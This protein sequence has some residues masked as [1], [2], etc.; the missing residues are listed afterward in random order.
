MD[1]IFHG[2][3]CCGIK[4]IKDLR[5]SPDEVV[6]GLSKINVNDAD[7]YGHNVSSETRFFHREAPSESRKDRLKRYI[8]YCKERRPQGMIEI[9][10]AVGEHNTWH[11]KQ[12][13]P[14]LKEH[15][16]NLVTSFLNSNSENTVEVW[17]LVYDE[18]PDPHNYDDGGCD[19]PDCSCHD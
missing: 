14:I 2:G 10:L 11:Q 3:L 16:F 1:L 8:E 4:I 9:T 12:W 18:G 13:A 6:Q 5:Y 15:G 7:Q 19:D 17:H